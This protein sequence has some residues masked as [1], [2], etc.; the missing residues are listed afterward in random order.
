[1]PN[2][3]EHNKTEEL[4]SLRREYA[5]V[6]KDMKQALKIINADIGMKNCILVQ[7][8]DT[9]TIQGLQKSIYEAETLLSKYEWLN[10]Y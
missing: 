10:R 8:D 4:L 6:L 7:I 2:D 1:M 5:D 9:T 3:I